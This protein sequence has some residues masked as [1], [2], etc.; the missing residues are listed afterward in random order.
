VP[1][2]TSNRSSLPEI[3]NQ[4]AYLV[5]PNRP[6]EIADAIIKILTDE[7]LREHFKKMG[8]EQIKRFNWETAAKKWLGLLQS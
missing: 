4:A 5:N 7:K 8:L 6:A 3:T 2:I 1:V